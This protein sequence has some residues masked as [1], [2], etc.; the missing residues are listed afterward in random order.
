MIK[1]Y[2][3]HADK[4]DRF[5]LVAFHDA[6]GQNFAELDAK[7]VEI[8]KKYWGGKKLPFPV[9]LDKTGATIKDWDIMSF[10]TQVL[11]DPQG[12]LLG[13]ANLETL[14]RALNKKKDK[15][16]KPQPRDG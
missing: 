7:L 11:I 6:T 15:V 1:F 10:P 2:D 4:R 8:R 14:E 3:K 16:T 5:E 13:L 12:R 9:L